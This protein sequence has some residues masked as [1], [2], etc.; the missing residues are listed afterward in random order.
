MPLISR[1]LCLSLI[2]NSLSCAHFK[3]IKPYNAVLISMVAGGVTG[4]LLQPDS[5]LSGWSLLAGAGIAGSGTSIYLMSGAT[6][7]V[8]NED[9]QT[10]QL[11][12]Q[13]KGKLQ[14]IEG[15]ES[16][17]VDWQVFKVNQWMRVRSNEYWH[18]DKQLL[19]DNDEK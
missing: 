14:N 6:N 18:V 11:L 17:S 19:I 3:E 13:G 7:L 16:Q 2:L 1:L 10:K 9:L 4:F 8:T 15:F 12:D 5:V